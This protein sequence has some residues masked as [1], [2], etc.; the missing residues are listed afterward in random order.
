M[1]TENNNVGG[2][3]GKGDKGKNKLMMLPSELAALIDYTK[4]ITL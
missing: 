1:Y 2:G 4:T 3:G